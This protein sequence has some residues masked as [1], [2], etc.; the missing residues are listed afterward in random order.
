MRD[1][2]GILP[3]RDLKPGARVLTVTLTNENFDL[4]DIDWALSSRGFQVEH[5]VPA[6][7]GG[8]DPYVSEVDAI[9]VN[10]TFRASWGVGSPRSIGAHNRTFMNGFHMEHPRVVFTSFGSPYHLR[11]FCGLP[12]YIN[13]HSMSRG[14][15]AA[16]VKAWFG[17]I[18]MSARSPVGNLARSFAP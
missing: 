9:F 8:V 1:V 7:Y 17:E 4:P 3:L 13:V 12:T 6:N 2:N 14:S 5:V 15:Q 18:P 16:V 11:Q 10:F